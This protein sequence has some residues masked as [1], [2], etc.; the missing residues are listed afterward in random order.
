MR[1]KQASYFEYAAWIETNNRRIDFSQIGDVEIVSEFR[2]VDHSDDADPPLLFETIV[3]GGVLDGLKW[4]YSTLGEVKR[5]HHEAV[6][7]VK[8]ADRSH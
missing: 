7:E 1:P 3:S 5:G 8:A 6:A 4:Q 2:G